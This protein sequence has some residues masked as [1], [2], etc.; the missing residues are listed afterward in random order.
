MTYSDKDP[1][2]IIEGRPLACYRCYQAVHLQKQCP[3]KIE[4]SEEEKRNEKI[5][6]EDITEETEEKNKEFENTTQTNR[7]REIE[8]N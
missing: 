1:N 7:K 4:S 8:N 6:Y 3:L 5:V 2:V